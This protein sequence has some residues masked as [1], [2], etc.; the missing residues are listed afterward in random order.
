[1]APHP[2]PLPCALAE[3]VRA[4]SHSEAE[5][6]RGSEPWGVASE[7]V[8]DDFQIQEG[9]ALLLLRRLTARW[10]FPQPSGSTGGDSHPEPPL[11]AI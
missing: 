3:V 5:L 1:M 6:L 10:C 7:V 9:S 11:Y 4:L 8:V 2:I